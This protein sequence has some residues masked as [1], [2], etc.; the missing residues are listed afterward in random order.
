MIDWKNCTRIVPMNGSAR[1]ALS[2]L[3]LTSVLSSI[4]LI[5]SSCACQRVS[6][7][8]YVDTRRLDHFA[9]HVKDLERSAAFYKSVFNF[10]IIHKWT[11]TWMVGND[12]IRVGLFLRTNAVAITNPDSFILI[13]H[14][15]FLT[16]S[17]GFEQAI[18]GLDQFG[19]KHDPPEDTG[20]ANSVFFN[21]PDG[22]LLE[23]T[24]YYK[25]GPKF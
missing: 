8:Q 12:S 18:K 1:W 23:I 24:A 2:L 16:D 5:L 9:V 21:D 13:E 14:V 6:T 17:N 15:A 22:N 11:T 7:N 19:I 20:I 25:N 10:D 4:T 3:L